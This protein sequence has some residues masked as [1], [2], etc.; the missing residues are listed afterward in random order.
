MNQIVQGQAFALFAFDIGYEVSLKEVG[1]LIDA[2]RLQPLSRR[3]QTPEY[4]QYTDPPQVLVLGE[5]PALDRWSG[6]VQ[7]TLFDFGAVSIAMRWPLTL[8]LADLPTLSARLAGMGLEALA[9]ERVEGLIEKLRPAIA[10]PELSALVED[11]YLFVVEG[12]DEPLSADEI[13]ARHRE[14]LAQTLS[15][16]TRPLSRDQQEETLGKPISYYRDDLVLVAWN[17]A[18]IYD[19]EYADTV[20]V[21]ELLNVELLEARYIDAQLDRQLGNYQELVARRLASFVPLSTPFRKSID[22]LAE[23]RIEYSILSERVDNALK[24]IGDLYLARVH[25]AA[26]E[27][28]YLREWETSISQK[29]DIAANLYQLLTDRL[30]TAQ[31]QTLELVIIA[32]IL[33]E[34][35]MA[36][37]R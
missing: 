28:F 15:F 19:R 14:V 2:S 35:V 36:L 37:W 18:I 12:F 7:A 16:E 23:L 20:S 5:A 9:R 11:Y 33:V 8:P 32:L 24:L 30:N 13:L 1:R 3:R 6:Q 29:L 34:V 27:R 22:Q 21:L 31:G 26:T 4:L 17:A 25:A 10:R